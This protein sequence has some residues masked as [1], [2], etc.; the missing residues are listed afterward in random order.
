[1]KFIA[2]VYLDNG[3][4][5]RFLMDAENSESAIEI[6]KYMMNTGFIECESMLVNTKHI[7]T[8]KIDRCNVI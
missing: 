5:D 7:C 4:E 3:E 8:V 6:A 2:R 1:M